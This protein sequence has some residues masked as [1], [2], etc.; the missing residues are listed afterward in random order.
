MAKIRINR[1]EAEDAEV[2]ESE[3]DFKKIAIG[4][5]LIVLLF[6]VGS[7]IFLP[8]DQRQASTLGATSLTPTPSLPD[9]EDIEAVISDAREKLSQITA[10]NITSSGAAVQKIIS[11]LQGIQGSGGPVGFMCNLVC[12]E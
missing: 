6:I 8:N 4:L 1:D 2:V 7:Y 9:R 12:K 10:E 3:W 5:I 11:D